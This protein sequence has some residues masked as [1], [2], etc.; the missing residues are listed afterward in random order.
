MRTELSSLARRLLRKAGAGVQVMF[1][2]SVSAIDSARLASEIDAPEIVGEVSSAWIA[3]SVTLPPPAWV[4]A[5][6]VMRSEI[7]A[8]SPRAPVTRPLRR[9]STSTL[10][11][12]IAVSVASTCGAEASRPAV[13]S[14]TSAEMGAPSNVRASVVTFSVARLAGSALAASLASAASGTRACPSNLLRRRALSVGRAESSGR[15]R[16]PGSEA[17]GM[18]PMTMSPSAASEAKKSLATAKSGT[19]APS[20]VLRS[21]ITIGSGKRRWSFVFSTR[22]RVCAPGSAAVPSAGGLAAARTALIADG[23]A[24]RKFVPP[25]IAASVGVRRR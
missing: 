14:S 15:A 9:R 8:V 20:G 10:A 6:G 19:I 1:D 21:G 5:C 25:V 13:A 24:M 18:P 7:S 23:S 11:V 2:A 12:L 3:R 4:I 22:L 16:P 17:S